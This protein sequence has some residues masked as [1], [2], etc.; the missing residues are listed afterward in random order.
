MEKE[1]EILKCENILLVE[2]IEKM[3]NNNRITEE[4]KTSERA[5]GLVSKN[6]IF[7][8]VTK[9]RLMK[10]VITAIFTISQ[11]VN[12]SCECVCVCDCLFV[13]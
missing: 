13:P 9:A 4:V 3:N 5:E 8:L 6:Q 10:F 7:S 11:Y 12:Q 1:R 2:E